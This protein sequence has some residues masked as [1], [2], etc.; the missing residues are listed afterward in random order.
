MEQEAM[1]NKKMKGKFSHLNNVIILNTGSTLKENI[2]N[3]HLVT[4]IIMVSNPVGMT[5]NAGT[6]RLAP[7][8]SVEVLGHAWYG[9]TQVDNIFGLSPLKKNTES[10][11]T[12]T[13][14][15]NSCYTQNQELI[16]L[17]QIQKAYKLF[18]HQ[19]ST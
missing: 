17:R 10:L 5:T 9:P 6:K 11:M 13:S 8:T 4:D 19:S 2:V 14:K 12:M 18:N 7:N 1:V 3:P 16:N 15:M